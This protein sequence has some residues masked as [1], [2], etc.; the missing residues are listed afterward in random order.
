MPPAMLMPRPPV[1]RTIVSVSWKQSRHTCPGRAVRGGLPVRPAGDREG[2]V[3]SS[4]TSAR[5]SLGMREP[6]EVGTAGQR[7]AQEGCP[8]LG[9]EALRT[10]RGSG[11][12]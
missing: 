2:P 11:R 9:D 3:L 10:G 8:P 12:H 6:E 7:A 5:A 4:N 1:C